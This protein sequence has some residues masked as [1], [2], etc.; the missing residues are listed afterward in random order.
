MNSDQP[1]IR[2]K[3]EATLESWK[4]IAQYLQRNDT[5]ARR[6]EREEGLPVHRHAHKGRASVYA[7]PSELDAWRSSRRVTPEPPRPRPLWKIPAF[8]ATILLCLIMVG[9][10]LRPQTASA[11]AANPTVREL[12]PTSQD[13]QGV[14]PDGRYIAAMDW[15]QGAFFLHDV[16]TQQDTRLIEAKSGDY[17]AS[18]AFSADSSQI[19]YLWFS[20]KEN[21][22][23]LRVIPIRGGTPRTLQRGAS[24]DSLQPVSW[25]ADGRRILAVRRL[26][27]QTTQIVFVS[28]QDG[29]VQVLKSVGWRYTDVSLSPD[30]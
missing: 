15:N 5:T 23:E 1:E 14:S 21:R 3:E 17:A 13:V 6:W 26:T 8:A 22:D 4:E 18:A 20:A 27:D 24:N 16:T 11:Q 25:T 7:Y 30:E 9:N 29:S 28:T 12:W 2:Q 10:G 19:A